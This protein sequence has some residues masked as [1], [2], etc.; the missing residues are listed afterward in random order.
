MPPAGDPIGG[1][2][3]HATRGDRNDDPAGGVVLA[4]VRPYAVGLLGTRSGPQETLMAATPDSTTAQSRILIVDDNRQNLELLEVYLED[5]PQVAISTAEDGI[6]AMAKITETPPD[7][8]LLDIM[9]PRM[10]GFEVC[11]QVKSNPKTRDILVVMVTALNETGDIERAT[12]CGADD[13]LSKPID[14][15]ALVNLVNTLLSG[16][17][18]S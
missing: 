10:S 6:E 11:K 9:M 7:L 14:R 13:Y 4:P 17:A 12:E 2:L 8:V 5:L 15:K 3:S 1:G 18:N 16:R